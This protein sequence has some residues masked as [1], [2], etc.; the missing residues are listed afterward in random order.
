MKY[1]LIL[2]IPIQLAFGQSPYPQN[3]FINPLDVTTV[4]SGTFGE[5][6]NNHFHS[7]LDIKTQQVEGLKVYAV[8]DGYVSRIKISHFGYGKALYITHP[9]GYT[10]VYAHLQ[11]LSPRLESYLK[12]IQ[13]QRETYEIE[14]FPDI[15]EFKITQGEVIAFSGNTGSSGGPHLHFEIRDNEE[16]PINPLLFGIEVKDTNPPN[17]VK[18]FVYPKDGNSFINGKNQRTE[19]RLIPKGNS[20]FEVEKISA[21]GSIGFGIIA[22]DRQDLAANQNGVS[23]ITTTVNGIKNFEIDFKR[24]SFDETS[25]LNRFIDYE[26]YKLQRSFI[27]KLFVE[28]NNPLSMFK[29]VVENGYVKVEDSISAIYKVE[30]SDFSGNVSTVSVVVNGEKL[31][32]ETLKSVSVPD[33]KYHFI[34]ANQDVNLQEQHVSVYIPENT[35]Y[36][37]IHL[38]FRVS[39][40]TLTLHEDLI[41]L[42]KNIG[43]NYDVSNYQDGDKNKLF[44]AKITGYRKYINYIPTI[45]KGNM[46]TAYTKTLGQFVLKTDEKAPS[47]SPFNFQ[48]NK[49]LSNYRYLKVK[50]ADDLSGIGTY[51]ATVNGKYLL[52]EYDYKTGILTHDFNDLVVTDTRNEL[53]I[54]VTDNVGNNTTFE[55]T[56]FRK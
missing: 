53:K 36:D 54:I 21:T 5:L 49:W 2:L 55:A 29:N 40:D 10:S 3:Y 24:F 6:R 31:I 15:D 44:I 27:K 1:C 39:G 32:K 9:N 48:N 38:D 51:R 26:Y 56:F 23:N 13:Y 30:V 8:A 12:F 28:P 7:G 34:Y 20:N 33:G 25:H 50:I 19:L 35:F 42:Q 22:Y 41:P 14:L 4:L 47:I 37:D 45:K 16:R 43:I 46:L 17:I 11:K 52:M 18:F